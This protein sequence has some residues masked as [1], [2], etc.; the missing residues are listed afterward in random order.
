MFSALMN[1]CLGK[2]SFIIFAR[3]TTL[4]E[5]ILNLLIAKSAH[6]FFFFLFLFFAFMYLLKLF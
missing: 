3:N 2:C 4:N 6:L 5:I 1:D